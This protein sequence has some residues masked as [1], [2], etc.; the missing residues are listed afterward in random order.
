MKHYI[1]KLLYL[2]VLVI[3]I[4]TFFTNCHKDPIYAG[5][6][7]VLRFSNDTLTF[8]TVFATIGS[9]TLSMKVYNTINSDLNINN[10]T[11]GGGTNS[12]YRLNIDGLAAN[13]ATNVKLR[14]KDSLMIFV[15]VTIDPKGENNPFIVKDSI[16]F[17]VNAASSQVILTAYG[18]EVQKLKNKH[19]Q[20]TTITADKPYLV[21]DTLFI[22]E[23]AIVNI[24]AG[25]KFYMHKDA[26]VVVNGTLLASGSKNAPILFQG[27]RLEDWFGNA[28]GLWGEIYLSPKSKDHK[29]KYVTIK[30]GNNGLLCDS[31]GLVGNPIEISNV[32]IEHIRQNGIMASNS[33]LIVTNTLIGNCSSHGVDIQFG[34]SYQFT[35]CTISD[36]SNANVSRV[37]PAIKMGN[38]YVDDNDKT[39]TNPLKKASF[40]NSIIVGSNSQEIGFDTIQI[41]SEPN[42]GINY[43]FHNS[44]L[45]VSKTFNVSDTTHYKS[46]IINK[47]PK[48]INR[49]SYDYHLD[50]LSVAKDAGLIKLALPVQFDYDQIDRTLDGKPDLGMYE[51]VDNK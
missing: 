35:H 49:R 24:N 48:F 10:I 15:E 8:D 1:I 47:D 46:I 38:K 12:H 23:G 2:S 31:T 19:F 30:N 51:Q 11:L 9:A 6:D 4:M 21:Y 26:C 22:D 39:I 17:N 45:F 33:N 44:L 32:R 28:V 16:R 29:L 25:A 42:N 13:N 3:A 7:N 41:T 36:Y 27:D 40:E 50:T 37:G 14:A 43:L 18:Q 20:S 5:N 34:G